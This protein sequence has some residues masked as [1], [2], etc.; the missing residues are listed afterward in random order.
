MENGC[1]I[2]EYID[3]AA[4]TPYR[5][6]IFQILNT[7]LNCQDLLSKL[8]EHGNTNQRVNNISGRIDSDVVH[9][10]TQEL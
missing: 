6:S 5:K 7:S 8:S 4:M 9:Y 10:I 1:L 2:G 3:L